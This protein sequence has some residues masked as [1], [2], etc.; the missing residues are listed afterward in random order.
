MFWGLESM[1]KF[2]SMKK[3]NKL[4]PYNVCGAREIWF[5][6]KIFFRLLR[7][8]FLFLG[9]HKTK[10]AAAL[11]SLEHGQKFAPDPDAQRKEIFHPQLHG[12]F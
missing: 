11:A 7:T 1:P 9:F 3:C 2:C 8:S 4:E 6:F 5:P 10:V 12:S